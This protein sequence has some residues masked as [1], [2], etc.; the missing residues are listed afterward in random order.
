MTT[1]GRS[2]TA[3]GGQPFF[4]HLVER[5]Y[6]HVAVDP[7]LLQLYPEQHDLGPARERL[8]LTADSLALAEKSF[9]LGESDLVAL[10]RARSM[11]PSVMASLHSS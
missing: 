8:A 5:F 4:D 7:V 10:L 3:V 11:S 1:D 9:H 2:L 6:E